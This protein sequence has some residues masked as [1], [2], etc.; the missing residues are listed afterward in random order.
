MTTWW[1][2]FK[3]A[4]REP[5]QRFLGVAIVEADDLR[6][7]I[8]RVHEVKADPGGEVM[9]WILNPD[10]ADDPERARAMIAAMPRDTLL[11][12]AQIDEMWASFGLE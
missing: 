9:S 7:A 10:Q 8:R 2:S 11:D 6:G 3:D 5:G 1:L 12:R 4:S